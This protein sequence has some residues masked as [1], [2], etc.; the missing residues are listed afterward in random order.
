MG[1]GG[2]RPDTASSSNCRCQQI[3]DE[4]IDKLLT[5]TLDETTFNRLKSQH[6]VSSFPLR[7]PV[8]VSEIN[9]LSL[10]S[11]LNTLSGY[12]VPLHQ[13]TGDGAYQN[14]VKILLGLFIT[15][16]EED[17][18]LS[19]QGLKDLN[20]D[21]VAGILGVSLFTEKP[22]E[23]LP[24]V[25]I[26]TRDGGGEVGEAIRLLV[27]ACNETGTILVEKGYKNLGEFVVE[28]LD[29]A[30]ALVQEKGDLAG[31]DHFVSR[32]SRTAS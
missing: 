16:G 23:S 29:E 32:V 8:L 4:A 5:T 10:L 21:D 31:A 13:A 19:A 22:H 7:F 30:E 15:G 6:G 27:K 2:G 24:G 18:F 28:I 12:R 14:V 11:L 26:G 3:S 20:Q 9:F 17:T 25:T 1:R